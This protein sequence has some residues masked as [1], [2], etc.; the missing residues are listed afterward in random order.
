ME[1]MEEKD[2]TQNY[3]QNGVV[4][5]ISSKKSSLKNLSTDFSETTVFVQ[6]CF[7]KFCSF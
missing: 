5:V 7:S 2:L 1:Y 3:M 6:N 4:K